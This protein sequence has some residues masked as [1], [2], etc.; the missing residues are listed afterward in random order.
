VTTEIPP[1]SARF[2][3]YGDTHVRLFCTENYMALEP[4]VTIAT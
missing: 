2:L 3:L 1:L 4:I